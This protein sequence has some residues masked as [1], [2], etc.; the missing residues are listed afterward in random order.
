MLFKKKE[1]PRD[2]SGK[3]AGMKDMNY[4]VLLIKFPQLFYSFFFFVILKRWFQPSKNHILAILEI[5]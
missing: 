4:L 5:G 2:K 1:K 3:P